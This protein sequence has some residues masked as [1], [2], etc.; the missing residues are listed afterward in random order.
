M[1][2][3]AVRVPHRSSEV[4][5]ARQARDRLGRDLKRVRAR[6]E[7]VGGALRVSELLLLL[8]LGLGGVRE[9]DACRGLRVVALG[10]EQA[11]LQADDVVAQGVV[12]GL[13]AFVVEV[14]FVV[15]ADLLF[16]FFY[17]AFFSLAEGPLC[18]TRR[19]SGGLN[20]RKGAAATDLG[21]SILGGALGL[22]ELALGLAAVWPFVWVHAADGWRDCLERAG[23][24]SGLA[25]AGWDHIRDG[26]VDG[27]RGRRLV[28]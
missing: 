1:Q 20:L 14:H 26:G 17:V 27:S 15:V 13:E 9:A 6:R 8:L 7:G 25:G 2:R 23:H 5:P 16:E 19:I 28:T 4:L 22:G 10:V 24:D 11:G 12:F 18:Y 3:H 21:G